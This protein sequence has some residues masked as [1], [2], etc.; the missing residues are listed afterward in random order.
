MML[1]IVC[2]KYFS[3]LKTAVMMETIELLLIIFIDH[4]PI[5]IYFKD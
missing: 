5:V 1:L 3:P 4:P 2:S